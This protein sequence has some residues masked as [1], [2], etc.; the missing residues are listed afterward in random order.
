MNVLTEAKYWFLQGIS[1]LPANFFVYKFLEVVDLLSRLWRF[2]GNL[3][4]L[5][6]LFKINEEIFMISIVNKITTVPEFFLVTNG[7]NIDFV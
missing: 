6:F 1:F 3:Y 2:V 5:Y 4:F 7:F